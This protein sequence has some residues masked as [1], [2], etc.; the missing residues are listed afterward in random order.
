M[1]N[2]QCSECKNFYPID[3]FEWT[4]DRYGIP[5]RKVCFG[6]YDKA[7]AENCDW[8]FDPADAGE[9]LEEV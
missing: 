7:Q 6:C 5:W 3:E 9:S 8:T 1:E 2:R 4:T